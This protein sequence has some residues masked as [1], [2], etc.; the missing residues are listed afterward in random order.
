MS[1][2]VN[3]FLHRCKTCVKHQFL[4]TNFFTKEVGNRKKTK[5]KEKKRIRI[6]T[7]T[8]Y[9]YICMFREHFQMIV[10]DPCWRKKTREKKFTSS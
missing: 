3:E 10:L 2:S 9:T 7:I 6:T 5:R 1:C 4:R 8:I